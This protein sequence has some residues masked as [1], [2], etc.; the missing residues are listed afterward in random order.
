MQ[1]ATCSGVGRTSRRVSTKH[2]QVSPTVF[3]AR[4]ERQATGA[5]KLVSTDTVEE[6]AAA[7]EIVA[8]A[9]KPSAMS[10]S[11]PQVPF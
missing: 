6:A 7:A 10:F 1:A 2:G 11:L 5:V 8:R 9:A 3:N 4:T